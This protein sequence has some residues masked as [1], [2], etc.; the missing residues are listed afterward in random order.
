M[1]QQ[2]RR[3]DLITRVL[4]LEKSVFLRAYCPGGQINQGGERN[5]V[6]YCRKIS[7]MFPVRRINFFSDELE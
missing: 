7:L 5:T 4:A 2:K 3:S 1:R 6:S